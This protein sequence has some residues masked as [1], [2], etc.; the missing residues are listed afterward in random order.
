MVAMN[1]TQPGGPEIYDKI[2]EA[3]EKNGDLSAKEFRRMV[4]LALADLGRGRRDARY[5]REQL[6]I[7][8]KRMDKLEAN[9]LIILAKKHTK[10]TAMV[11]GITVLFFVSVISH[12]E[13]WIWFANVFKELTGVPLP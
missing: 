13:L 6:D 3:L 4:L 1:P 7:V 9:S 10:I 11:G 8:N 12:L 5:C 2:I